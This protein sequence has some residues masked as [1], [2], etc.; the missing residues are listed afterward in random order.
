MNKAISRSTP[1]KKEFMSFIQ[2]SSSPVKNS[3]IMKNESI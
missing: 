2:K 1:K 3:S